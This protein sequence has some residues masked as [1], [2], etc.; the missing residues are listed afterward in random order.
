MRVL[1]ARA[2]EGELIIGIALISADEPERR[3]AMRAKRAPVRHLRRRATVAIQWH[4][5][6]RWVPA[7]AVFRPT[8]F[9][10]AINLGSAKKLGLKIPPTVLAIADELID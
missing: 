2:L 10:L 8:K 4:A 7:K 5:S 1:A 6:P 3:P 9:E